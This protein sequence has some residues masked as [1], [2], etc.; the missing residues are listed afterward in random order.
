MGAEG[1]DRFL[2]L[3]GLGRTGRVASVVGDGFEGWGRTP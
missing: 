3:V 1:R 2:G